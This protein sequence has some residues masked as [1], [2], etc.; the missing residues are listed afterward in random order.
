M[1]MILPESCSLVGIVV[2]SPCG[3]YL[4]SGSWWNKTDKV[5][6]RLWEVATGENIHT[7]WG[8]PQM[9]KISLFQRMVN[10]WQVAVMTGPS[11]FG[12]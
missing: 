4:A 2:F 10:S 11:C 12:I 7:F 9:F 1:G 5:S 3:R 8:I 6:I